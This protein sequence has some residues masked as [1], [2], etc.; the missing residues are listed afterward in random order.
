V[1]EPGGGTIAGAG[2]GELA[3]VAL[4]AVG[5]AA[6]VVVVAA[7]DSSQAAP[8]TPMDPSLGPDAAAPASASA[9]EAPVTYEAK[10]EGVQKTRSPF[11]PGTDVFITLR[12]QLA[13]QLKELAMERSLSTILTMM[14]PPITIQMWVTKIRVAM[15]TIIIPKGEDRS[16]CLN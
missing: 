10:K 7:S 16:Y 4:A 14:M 13:K 2:L 15:T 9:S 8:P 11:R 6:V 5:T 1:V 12:K 3:D